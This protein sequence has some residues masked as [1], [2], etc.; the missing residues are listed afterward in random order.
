MLQQ[1][2][3]QHENTGEQSAF[4]IPFHATEQ[5]LHFLKDKRFYYYGLDLQNASML[6]KEPSRSSLISC[7]M[8]TKYLAWEGGLCAE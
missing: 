3:L 8:A 6:P 1:V 5:Q 4:E 2:P 7:W